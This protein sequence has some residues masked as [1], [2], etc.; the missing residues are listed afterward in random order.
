[1]GTKTLAASFTTGWITLNPRASIGRKS[2]TPF[3]DSFRR[4]ERRCIRPVQPG[5]GRWT[6]TGAIRD[7]GEKRSGRSCPFERPTRQVTTVAPQ[8]PPL[9]V[10]QRLEVQPFPKRQ[11][12]ASQFP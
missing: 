9:S 8:L 4:D 6:F 3:A 12:A 11:H 2:P 1:M 7:N 5:N 10:E